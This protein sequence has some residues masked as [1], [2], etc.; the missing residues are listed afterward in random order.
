M[1]TSLHSLALL[2]VLFLATPTLA[3]APPAT[4]P[5][6]LPATPTFTPSAPTVECYDFLEIKLALPFRL[7]GANQPLPNPFT[8][9]SFTGTFT[10]TT[11]PQL[12]NP[13]RPPSTAAANPPAN[14]TTV[15]GFCDSP[16]GMIYRIRFMPTHPGIY[17]YSLNLHQPNVP[18][19][20]HNGTFTATRSQRPGPLRVDPQYPFHFLWEG[21][22]K[23]CFVN[24]TTAFFLMGWQNDATIT[25]ILDRLHSLDINRLRI[26]LGGRSD[27][28]WT[29]PIKPTN[30]FHPYL[31]PWQAARPDNINN[32]GFDFTRFNPAYWQRYE[33]MLKYARDK[34]M[35]VSTVFFWNDDNAHPAAASDDERRY[36]SYAVS[37]LAAFSNIA[38]DLGDDLDS[39]RDEKWTHDTGTFLHS[40]DPYH[41]LATSHPVNN[42]HQ[43]RTAA[44]FTNTSFQEWHRPLHAWM[45]EQRQIQAKTGRIIP[46][47]DEEYGYEDHYPEWAP[48][49][50]PAANAD[51]NRRAA[52]QISM[53]GCYQ[54]T[55]ETAKRGTGV[56]P[57]T[58]GG[59]V[60]G[61]GDQTMTM[62]NSYATMARFFQSV[63][64]VES[65]PPR[66]P[67]Q[68]PQPRRE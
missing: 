11:P 34:D 52:W 4:D 46:Q 26:L 67:R 3:Q 45:I 43:D 64:L 30:D 61:R 47:L 66:R 18:D 9:I 42:D 20:A 19:I 54:T 24:G 6:A 23:H 15:D 68:Q 37:R 59:W 60:N 25:A 21:T 27:H 65:R 33:R 31:N 55:G 57:D 35:I 8:E 16:D 17:S 44:W 12:S 29:E 32:P 2:A 53:A 39:F 62:L 10:L 1:P 36:F 50:P 5:A 22:Q 48:Y 63:Q 41:H 49:K 58:G 7:T 14:Q 13:I 51:G 28:T 56:P 38:W 40:I